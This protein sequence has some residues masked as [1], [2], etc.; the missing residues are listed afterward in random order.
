MVIIEQ[1]TMHR[2]ILI[3]QYCYQLKVH[4]QF[5]TVPKIS[6]SIACFHLLRKYL[7][8]FR[9]KMNKRNNKYHKIGTIQTTLLEDFN[10]L[11]I[12]SF[13]LNQTTYT[14]SCNFR[15]RYNTKLKINSLI[16]PIRIFKNLPFR[17]GFSL[18]IFYII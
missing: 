9:F 14:I 13:K 6:H 18:K 10:C 8:I 11:N 5:I 12:L 4:Y 17:A 16:F 3:S 2:I 15:I 1:L 7:R